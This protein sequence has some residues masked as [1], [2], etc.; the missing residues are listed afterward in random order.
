MEPTED[1]EPL[2]PLYQGVCRM[3]GDSWVEFDEPAVCPECGSTAVD[4]WETF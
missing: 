3:C 4:G 2:A 1:H